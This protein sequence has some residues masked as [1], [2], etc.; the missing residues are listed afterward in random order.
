MTR[1]L[2]VTDDVF[3]VLSDA[4]RRHALYYLR[5]HDAAPLD[6]LADVVAGWLTVDRVTITTPTRRER[7][8][9]NLHHVHLPMLDDVGFLTYDRQ[10]HHA[11]L[12][13]LSAEVEALL[14]RSLSVERRAGPENAP[15]DSP[16]E[17]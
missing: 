14:D 4:R 1:S 6:E 13:D 16:P 9:I 17:G 15:T 12:R 2:D 3:T 11:E 8:R 10:G 5:E 7:I